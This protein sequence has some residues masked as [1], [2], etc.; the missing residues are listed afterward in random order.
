MIASTGGLTFKMLS[1]RMLYTI[2]I[3]MLNISLIV[4]LWS[5][6]RLITEMLSSVTVACNLILSY[7]VLWLRNVVV[8]RRPILLL[9][10]VYRACDDIFCKYV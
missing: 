7:Q 5:Y 6:L 8:G 9:N 2:V 4:S 1:L 3:T 10:T